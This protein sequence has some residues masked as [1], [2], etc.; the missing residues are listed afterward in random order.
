MNFIS[1]EDHIVTLELSP[2]D[3]VV[4]A[5]VGSGA[6]ALAA[7]STVT[8]RGTVYAIDLNKDLLAR[9]YN[10]AEKMGLTNIHTLWGDIEVAGGMQVENKIADAVLVCNTFFMIENKD[11]LMEEVKRVLKDSGKLLVVDW[12]DSHGGVGPHTDHVFLEQDAKLLCE[13]HGFGII[14]AVD[15]AAHHYGFVAMKV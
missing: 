2:G 4:D 9:V 1:P 12:S 7:A 6:Y 10:D 8:D 3:I 14:C 5:G 15:G 13:R 11:G